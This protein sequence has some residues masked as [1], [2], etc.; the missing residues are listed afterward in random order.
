MID[1]AHL[2]KSDEPQ[3]KTCSSTPNLKSDYGEAFFTLFLHL[4]PD[5]KQVPDFLQ[6]C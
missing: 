3:T 5:S 4:H 2:Q 6:M 1:I